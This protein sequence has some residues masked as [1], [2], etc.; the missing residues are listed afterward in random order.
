MLPSRTRKADLEAL[1]EFKS[2]IDNL[3]WKDDAHRSEVFSW[4][5][6]S[7]IFQIIGHTGRRRADFTKYIAPRFLLSAAAAY[8]LRKSCG[9][10]DPPE[11][12]VLQSTCAA[13]TA[14]EH[15]KGRS[16][17]KVD[18]FSFHLRRLPVLYASARHFAREGGLQNRSESYLRNRD[19]R[20]RSETEAT[21]GFDRGGLSDEAGAGCGFGDPAE[22]VLNPSMH[23]ANA[24]PELLKK[25]NPC[26]ET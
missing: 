23:E 22:Q 25:I 2:L 17:S 16:V 3:F 13:R 18:T 26:K 5:L 11:Q 7:N 24:L 1:Y 8:G 15:V 14:Y 20:W 12:D 19:L 6:G 9:S 4:R 21:P 10:P